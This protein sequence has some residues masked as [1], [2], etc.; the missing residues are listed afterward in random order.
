MAAGYASVTGKVGA[1][2]TTHGVI[3]NTVSALF[4]AARGHHPLVLIVGDTAAED[5]YNLQNLPHR[6]N[7]IPTG[8]RFLDVRSAQTVAVDVARAVRLARVERAP[9]VLNIRVDLQREEVDYQPVEWGADPSPVWTP[10]P[11]AIEDAV[12]LISAARRPVVI[13]G[14]GVASIAARDVIVRLAGRIGA[15]L[16]TTL[17]G[18]DLFRDEPF[19]LGICGSLAVPLTSETIARA[20]CLVA[21]GASLTALTGDFGDLYAGKRIVQIDNDPAAIGRYYP[22]DVGVV[23][24]VGEAAAAM[25]ALWDEAGLK[26]A[27]YRSDALRAELAAYSPAD[28]PRRNPPGTIDLRDALIRIDE[29]V[30]RDRNLVVDAGRFLHEAL[31]IV[32]APEPGAYVHCLNVSQI[33]MSVGYG[34]GAAAGAPERPTLV[35]AGDG[36]FMLGGLAE[37]NTAVRHGLDL[38]VCVMNDNAYGAEY[39]RFAGDGADASLTTFDWPDLAPIATSLGGIGVTVRTDDDFARMAKVLAERD[40]PVLVD[41]KLDTATVPDPGRH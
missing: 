25:L 3:T 37:F 35:V 11:A 16:A 6:D 27:G 13:G 31:R 17:R 36:G 40:R 5:H 21:F 8:A 39:Y 24:D 28:F 22:V 30:D 41:V 34:I 1:A 38:V 18:K 2:T 29:I 20:D 19:N 23:G 33:G 9:V 14:R 12:G 4:D 32:H 7:V 10:Q 26:P 15:P